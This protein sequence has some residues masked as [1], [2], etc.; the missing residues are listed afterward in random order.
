MTKALK[1][2]L[3]KSSERYILWYFSL[4]PTIYFLT[5]VYRLIEAAHIVNNVDSMLL[6]KIVKRL[7][8]ECQVQQAFSA[9]EN[10]K[11]CEALSLDEK[12]LLFL[13]SSLSFVIQEVIV[14]VFF[15]NCCDCN[16]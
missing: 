12:K 14:L 9:Q 5:N 13:L 4:F 2:S 8:Q 11:L 1:M 3:I 6:T 7:C 16:T 10:E 15:Q